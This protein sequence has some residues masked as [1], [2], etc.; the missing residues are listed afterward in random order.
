MGE[1]IIVTN[2]KFSISVEV[3]NPPK[4][5]NLAENANNYIPEGIKLAA[6]GIE[7][8]LWTDPKTNITYK[9]IKGHWYKANREQLREVSKKAHEIIRSVQDQGA[10]NTS[11][12]VLSEKLIVGLLSANDDQSKLKLKDQFESDINKTDI[13]DKTKKLWIK[14]TYNSFEVIQNFLK[15]NNMQIEKV[16]HVGNKKQA[17]EY[18]TADLL[19]KTDKGMF[20]ISLK[21]TGNARLHNTSLNKNKSAIEG[22]QQFISNQD[23][24]LKKFATLDDDL[25][26][27]VPEE[28]KLNRKIRKEIFQK[29]EGKTAKSVLIEGKTLEQYISKERGK[30]QQGLKD[31]IDKVLESSNL[32]ENVGKIFE[33]IHG[34]TLIIVANDKLVDS[35]SIKKLERLSVAHANDGSNFVMNGNNRVAVLGIRQDGKGYGTSIKLEANLT[36]DFIRENSRKYV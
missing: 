6:K 30:L 34:G 14:Y 35:K 22:V 8:F 33:A 7:G 5:I 26:K 19:M 23:K 10:K 18:Y 15:E 31:N 24:L 32:V 28:V 20:G 21:K 4:K 3:K 27:Y 16:T 13:T 2:G 36:T 25:K 29:F 17:D 1:P 9:K 11:A 12:Y